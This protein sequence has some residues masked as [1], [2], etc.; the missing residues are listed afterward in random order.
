MSLTPGTQTASAESSID[1]A[2]QT[3]VI[4]SCPAILTQL[5]SEL[6][7][8]DPSPQKVSRLVGGDVALSLAVLKTINSPYYGL[9]RKVESVNQAVSMIGLRQIST[10]VTNVLMRDAAIF[11]GLNLVRFWDVSTKRSFG[12]MKLAKTLDSDDIESAQSFGLFCDIGIPLL[13]QRFPNYLDT[14]K[15]S[16]EAAHEPFTKIEFDRHGVEHGQIGA[17]MGKA[18]GLSETLCSAIR[19]HHDYT[20]FHDLHATETVTKLIAMNLVI[21]LAIQRFSQL[22]TSNEW[23]KGGE[24]AAGALMLSNQDIDDLVDSINSGFASGLD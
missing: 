8:A 23:N 22:N 14:L 13:L 2:L 16:N 18:W 20:I 12:M 1:A 11:K 5:Q 7:A 9:S 10:I 4:P 21:E 24:Y 19:R 3:I 17:M 6:S 15:L